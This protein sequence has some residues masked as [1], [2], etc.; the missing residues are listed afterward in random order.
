MFNEFKS[1]RERTGLTQQAFCERF[2]LP[3]GTYR[4]WEQGVNQ[5]P[6]YVYNLLESAVIY[7]DKWKKERG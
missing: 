2:D 3:I 7:F 5:P 1:L 6:K 4:N